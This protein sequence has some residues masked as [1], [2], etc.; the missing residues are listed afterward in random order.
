MD[1]VDVWKEKELQRD[2][3][4]LNEFA[5]EYNNYMKINKEVVENKNKLFTFS[6]DKQREII[7]KYNEHYQQLNKFKRNNSYIYGIYTKI[8]YRYHQACNEIDKANMKAVEIFKKDIDKH[9][10]TLQTK[11]ENKIGNIIQI[12]H[13]GGDNYKFIGELNNCNVE[14]ILAG[15]YNI[16]RLHTRWVI[17][18]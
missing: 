18:K 1:Y 8:M 6:E 16:Q 17:K 9:F 10:K 14:V 12:Q 2:L 13:L 3:Q 4:M 11:V 5:K 15:G 7:K